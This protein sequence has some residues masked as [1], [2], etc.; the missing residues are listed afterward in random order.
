[1]KSVV[2]ES[3][4]HFCQIYFK[5]KILVIFFRLNK[6]IVF[7]WCLIVVVLLMSSLIC[8]H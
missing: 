3:G 1:M 5:A 8:D 4:I 6:K 7:E 2:K